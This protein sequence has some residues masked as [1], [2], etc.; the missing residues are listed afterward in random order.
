MHL[1]FRS[2][3]PAQASQRRPHMKE[4]RRAEAA[5]GGVLRAG[6]QVADIVKRPV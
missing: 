1:D 3:S 6:K 5:K 2:P 4:K